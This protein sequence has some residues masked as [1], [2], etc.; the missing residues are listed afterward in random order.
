MIVIPASS[1]L[2]RRDDGIRMFHIFF[3]GDVMGHLHRTVLS[4]NLSSR[5]LTRCSCT[6]TQVVAIVNGIDAIATLAFLRL[7]AKPLRHFSHA[8]DECEASSHLSH[9]FSIANAVKLFG[10][11][12]RTTIANAK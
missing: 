3:L 2:H 8:S 5:T 4:V 7:Y 1:P 10:A 12:I 6:A 11:T 9:G